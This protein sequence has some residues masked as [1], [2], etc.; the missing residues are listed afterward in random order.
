MNRFISQNA[1]WL[2]P[3]ASIG[4]F[5]VLWVRSTLILTFYPRP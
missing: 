5:V 1:R 2:A 4:A 3:V